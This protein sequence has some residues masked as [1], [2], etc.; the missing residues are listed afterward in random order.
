MDLVEDAQRCFTSHLRGLRTS[1]VQ[2]SAEKR[3]KHTKISPLLMVSIWY[4]CERSV[5]IDLIMQS[6]WFK[7]SQA[8]TKT[9]K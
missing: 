4:V 7:I 6:L 8:K 9:Q 1:S 2:F 5:V 3:K